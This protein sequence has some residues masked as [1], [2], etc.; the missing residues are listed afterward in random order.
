MRCVWL[1]EAR[2]LLALSAGLA[3]CS[4]PAPVPP[5]AAPPAAAPPAPV[6]PG[7]VSKAAAPPV[8][9]APQPAVPSAAPTPE[10]D[11]EATRQLADAVVKVVAR[12]ETGAE[13]RFG[14]IATGQTVAQARAL[15]DLELF[16][17]EWHGNPVGDRW[18]QGG[19]TTCATCEGYA[20]GTLDLLDGRIFRAEV[21]VDPL[22]RP[23][24]ARADALCEKI[25]TQL[26]A[27]DGRVSSGE[28]SCSEPAPQDEISK[29]SLPRFS[30]DRKPPCDSAVESTFHF[31]LAVPTAVDDIPRATGTVSLSQSAVQV[32]LMLYGRHYRRLL[33]AKR[34]R[35]APTPY[36]P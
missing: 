3:A 30:R 29:W 26:A 9:V 15:G 22:P 13:L 36:V 4:S 23:A 12:A 1:W 21:R 28:C 11:R 34:A 33:A 5:A 31:A 18:K 7:S 14:V 10:Q 32:V 20:P 2:L 19:M 6:P 8:A 24:T 27:A 16:G 35:N 17:M 25:R